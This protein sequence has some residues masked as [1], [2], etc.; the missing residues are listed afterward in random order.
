MG[1]T[2]LSLLLEHASQRPH[3]AALREKEYGIWQ[4]LSW[5]ALAQLVRHLAGGLAQAGLRRGD[6]VVVIGEN[7]PRLYA[8]MLAAQSLGAVPVPLY[9]DSASA[10]FVFPI[11]NAEVAYAIVEDQE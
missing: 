6:H 3:A 10:E 11:V 9:Q 4:T 5:S 1:T 8:S 7:R 2:F